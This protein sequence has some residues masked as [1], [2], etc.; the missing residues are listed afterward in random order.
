MFAAAAAARVSH[1]TPPT[2]FILFA[3]YTFVVDVSTQAKSGKSVRMRQR[4][5]WT[6]TNR[7]EKHFS[8]R[9]GEK[10]RSFSF[11][12][13]PF[14]FS[15]RFQW[16]PMTQPFDRFTKFTCLYSSV[17]LIK[18]IHAFSQ[19]HQLSKLILWKR[20]KRFFG[21]PMRPPN[22]NGLPLSSSLPLFPVSFSLSLVTNW[23]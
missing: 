21:M 17:F 10:R 6:H 18:L 12:P 2:D 22:P 13:N 20:E 7:E 15:G 8:F 4:R 11:V 9:R 14:F 19:R 5:N 23:N 16:W 3:A 1:H